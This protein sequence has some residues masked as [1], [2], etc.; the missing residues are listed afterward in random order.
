MWWYGLGIFGAIAIVFGWIELNSRQIQLYIPSIAV[1][2][3]ANFVKYQPWE[4]DN[5]KVF[6]AGWIPIALGVVSQ[7]IYRLFDTGI[8]IIMGILI[9][10]FACLSGFLCTMIY[11]VSPSTIYTAEDWELGKWIGENTRTDAVFVVNPIHM[12]PAATIAGRQLFMGYGGW[13]VSHGLEYWMRNRKNQ[14]LGDPEFAST[15]KID[16]VIS[17]RGYFSEF[18]KDYVNCSRCIKVFKNE[19]YHVW[20]LK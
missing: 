19:K 1:F 6:Y 13:V 14:E 5:L 10:G 18:E 17:N 3:I 11:S 4:M 15:A 20:K 7:Y 12:H 9:T 16:Y 8:G 2:I